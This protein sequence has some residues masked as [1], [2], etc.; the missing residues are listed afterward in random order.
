M[1]L[2]C[3]LVTGC[4]GPQVDDTPVS[5][6]TTL[7][8]EG[9]PVPSL[10]DD[11]IAAARIA[12]H[13][14]V[15]GT[16]ALQTAFAGGVVHVWDFGPAEAFV[17]PLFVLMQPGG[18]VRVAHPTIID[19]VPGDPG[20]SPF[21]VPFVLEITAAY[22][23]EL[24][25]SFDAI[26]EAVERGLVLAPVPRDIAI[27]C[28]VV[29]AGV[30]VEVAR[31]EIASPDAVF[32]YRGTEIPYFD[33]GE[34]PLVAGRILESPR[35]RLRREGQ[36]PLSEITRRVDMTGDGD[37]NDSNDVYAGDPASLTTTPL[38]RRVDVVVRASISSI[39]TTQDE[40][41]AELA[42]ATQLFSPAPQPV[43]IGYE[44]TDE[45]H[46]LPGQRSPGGL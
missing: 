15:D 29:G 38:R 28:P 37:V 11:P 24:L 34:M 19:A 1:K 30:V 26:E 22:D 23:G 18:L 17:A 7:L 10:L 32:Y 43:V 9:T 41:L 3:L 4:L 40:T 21:W 14:G 25:T 36:E 31:G 39:D 45:L 12:D 42:A 6:T 5:A 35:Y 20:Y 13:D 27:N 46:N 2:A 16:I 8:P 33:F 44:E